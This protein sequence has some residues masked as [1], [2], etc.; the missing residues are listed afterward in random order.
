MIHARSHATTFAAAVAASPGTD[1]VTAWLPDLRVPA[2]DVARVAD[3]HA[4]LRRE[5]AVVLV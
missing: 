3:R 2:F 4:Q 1:P 5:V